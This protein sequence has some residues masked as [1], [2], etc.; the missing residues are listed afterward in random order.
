MSESLYHYGY[1]KMTFKYILGFFLFP[2]LCFHEVYH[3]PFAPVL[4]DR[5]I[6]Y[7]KS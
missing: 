7:I 2:D 6:T 3:L 1:L 4:Q 5:S